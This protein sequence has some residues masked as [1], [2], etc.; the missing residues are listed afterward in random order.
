MRDSLIRRI[1]PA[2][3]PTHG[4]GLYAPL[5]DRGED[6]NLARWDAFELESLA[7]NLDA[8]LQVHERHQFFGWTQGTLQSII[9]HD[10]LI[11]ALQ[12]QE[13]GALFV[14]SFSALPLDPAAISD[15]FR[16]DAGLAAH[17]I[18]LWETNRCR[19]VICDISNPQSPT[20]RNT[21][22]SPQHQT[23]NHS[24]G[25]P[26]GGPTGNA[27]A[28]LHD[29]ARESAAGIKPGPG[30]GANANF[31][32]GP[33]ARELLS[34]GATQLIVH[35][36]HNT[37]GK[38]ASLF[39]FCC[40]GLTISRRKTNLAE[41]LVPFLHTAWMRTQVNWQAGRQEATPAAANL[42]TAR[43]REILG[44]VYQGK[45]NIEIGIILNISSLTVKNHVQK[46]LRRLNVLNRTQAVG[47]ALALRILT[48]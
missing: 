13:F 36:T 22:T 4:P 1:N 9:E 29:A 45:S 3:D 41:L 5:A 8:A 18:R 15:M 21:Q 14:D 34:I 10:L 32:T 17:L 40:K 6:V 47:K 28:N 23:Q 48:L 44:W 20:Q 38:L 27:P 30:S 16:Q 24:T 35:G 33:L 46:I 25:N 43:E 12:T 39:V 11:C 2:N 26:H 31:S 7:L 37:A 19:A 42:L